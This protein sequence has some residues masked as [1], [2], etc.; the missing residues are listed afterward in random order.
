MVL[1]PITITLFA[2]PL[3]IIFSVN[4]LRLELCPLLVNHENLSLQLF[5]LFLETLQ[6]LRVRFR[7]PVQLLVKLI[8]FAQ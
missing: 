4:D 5:I 8:L 2:D 1:L 3:H 6:C 7:L